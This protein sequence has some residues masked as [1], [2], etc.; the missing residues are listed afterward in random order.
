MGAGAPVEGAVRV[1]GTGDRLELGDTTAPGHAT[2][3]YTVE[4]DL[5]EGGN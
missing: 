2:L 4:A 3:F 5:N 1:P